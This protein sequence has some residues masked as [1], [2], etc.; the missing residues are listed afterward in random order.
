MP[1]SL[2]KSMEG[3]SGVPIPAEQLTQTVRIDGVLKRIPVG[4][5]ILRVRQ[6]G[7]D[8]DALTEGLTDARIAYDP[9][10]TAVGDHL[11]HNDPDG[12]VSV[13]PVSA[14]DDFRRTPALSDQIVD[15]VDQAITE[16][17]ARN[18]DL[19][20]SG[21]EQDAE[22][23]NGL[24]KLVLAEFDFDEAVVRQVIG[25]RIGR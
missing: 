5:E 11:A 18:R 10:R 3:R 17:E 22:F 1:H 15:I 2:K 12:E 7:E 16:V 13:R 20:I 23:V 19:F 9:S 4:A 21:W 14:L 25:G 24:V 6:E 8:A